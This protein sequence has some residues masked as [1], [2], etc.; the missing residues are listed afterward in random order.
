MP[1]QKRCELAFELPHAASGIRL[2]IGANSIEKLPA[3]CWYRGGLIGAIVR[4]VPVPV[5]VKSNCGGHARRLSLLIEAF[6]AGIEWSPK[7][8]I[9]ESNFTPESRGQSD[10]LCKRVLLV[11]IEIHYS[12]SFLP[13]ACIPCHFCDCLERAECAIW[14][15]ATIE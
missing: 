1:H 11:G 7:G 3:Q 9:W 6:L 13:G 12:P 5:V 4:I 8:R 14:A 10:W 15:N 2:V